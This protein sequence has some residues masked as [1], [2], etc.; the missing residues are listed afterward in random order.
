ME[1]FRLKDGTAGCTANGRMPRLLSGRTGRTV[2]DY[3]NQFLLMEATFLL[4]TSDLSIAQIS[5]RLHFSD[6]A[7]FSKFFYRLQGISPQNYRRRP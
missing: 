6:Q 7:A 4:R 1:P 2:I 3:V 5:D